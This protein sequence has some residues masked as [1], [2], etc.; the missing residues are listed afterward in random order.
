[1][2]AL[3]NGI[4]PVIREIEVWRKSKTAPGG[5]AIFNLIATCHPCSQSE[6]LPEKLNESLV[7]VFGQVIDTRSRL[8]ATTGIELA[9]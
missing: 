2:N 6:R 3:C 1:M 7:L 4:T 9:T 8:A 5:A